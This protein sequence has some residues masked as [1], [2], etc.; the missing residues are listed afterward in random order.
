MTI[1]QAVW[2]ARDRARHVGKAAVVWLLAGLVAAQACIGIVTLVLVVPIWAGLLHQAF[3][4]IVLAMSVVHRQRLGA[5]VDRYVG[6]SAEPAA[7]RPTPRLEATRLIPGSAAPT[8]S[9]KVRVQRYGLSPKTGLPRPV[10]RMQA[11]QVEAFAQRDAAVVR[12]D[13]RRR[14]ATAGRL[15]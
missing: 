7:R 5:A 10:D 15:R 14:A 6:L 3:A 4:M 11:H 2:T 12:R 13:A 1:V 8:R 9:D